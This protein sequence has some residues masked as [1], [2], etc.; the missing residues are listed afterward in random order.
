MKHRRYLNLGASFT[1]AA[2]LAAANDALISK[3]LLHHAGLFIGAGP[4][5]D[6]ESEFP[7]IHHGTAHW[8]NIQA[9][10]LLKFLPNTAASIISQ[11]LEIH[12]ECATFC[13]AC[14]ASL[15]A[16]GDAYRKIKDGYLDI[17][18]A[19][20]GDSRLNSGAMMAYKKAQSLS[21][22]V[23]RPDLACRP[24]DKDRNGFVSGEGA[25][26]FVLESLDHAKKRG[27]RIVA[28]IM[29]FGASIDGYGMTAPQPDGLYAKKAVL[30]ACKQANISD[31]AIDVISAHGTGTQLND[32]MEADM[33]HDIFVSEKPSV[34]A[35]KSWM[36]HMAAACGAAELAVCLAC[37]AY[38]YIPE[39]R[40]LNQP[41]NNN[42][43]FVRSPQQKAFQTVLLENFGFG[44]QNSAIIVRRF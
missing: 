30:Q 29:G 41:C 26:F 28:E 44:G 43:N 9:L 3:Q 33:I 34:I 10:W 18:L 13:T 2:A 12:G 21:T 7:D 38:D 4:N 42:V 1:V 11:L 24:F 17:A 35:L 31:N 23:E 5:L 8:A 32:Q 27:A 25:A 37:M 39:I 22:G 40:N 6:I 20:G 19:G 36:G 16:I 15:Q 14:A